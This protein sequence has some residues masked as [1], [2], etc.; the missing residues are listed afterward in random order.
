MTRHDD[1]VSL[2]QMLDHPR[3]AVDMA[4]PRS[5]ADLDGDRLL[6]LA[7]TRLIEIIGEA[8]NRVSNDAQKEHLQIPWPQIVSM[9]NRIIH[10]YDDV[11]FDVLWN[12]IDLDLPPL[13]EQ[14][15]KIIKE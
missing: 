13:I 6:N 4:K 3:E 7:L 10:A 2:R 9:R 12:T 1:N 11:D 14:L 15:Q 5:R 8:A